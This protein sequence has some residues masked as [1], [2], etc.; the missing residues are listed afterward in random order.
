[1]DTLSHKEMIKP[2][3]VRA[4]MMTIDLKLSSKILNAQDEAIKKEN[5]KEEN[6]RGMTK[7]F[8]TRADGTLCI[9]TE[10]GAMI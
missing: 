9:E 8:E 10:L 6:L 5:V 7:E 3:R 1:A 4:L 2:L